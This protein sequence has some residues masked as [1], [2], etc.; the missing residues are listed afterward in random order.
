MFRSSTSSTAAA[1]GPLLSRHAPREGK[2]KWFS[3]APIVTGVRGR[4]LPEAA[5]ICN[6]PKGDE[7]DPGLLQYSDVVTYSTSSAT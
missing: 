3:A 4:A 7:N 6:F 1:R 2:D 5:L